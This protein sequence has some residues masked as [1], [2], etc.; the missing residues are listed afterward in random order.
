MRREIARVVDA[1]A[2]LGPDAGR[3]SAASLVTTQVR[4]A[5][6]SGQ[7]YCLG[8]GWTAAHRGRGPRAGGRGRGRRR[9]AD[10][11]PETTGDLDVLATLRRAAARPEPA[12]V[13]A[14]RAEL[15]DAAASVAK[16]WLLRHE[17]QGV[18]LPAAF[19]Q[20]HPEAIASDAEALAGT[21]SR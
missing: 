1:G 17:V 16:V 7:R 2:S 18:P 10:H 20:D 11:A 19:L 21:D 15:T 5:T 6:F 8:V 4:C 12:R 13:A 9:A 3:A 14:E